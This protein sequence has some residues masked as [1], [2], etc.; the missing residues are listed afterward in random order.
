MRTLAELTAL[1]RRWLGRDPA[2]REIAIRSE[3]PAWLLEAERLQG[4]REIPG[5]ESSPDIMAWAARQ[6]PWIRAIYNADEVPWC[7]LFA[8]HCVSTAGLS[9][10][11]T[12]LSALAWADWGT[13]LRRPVLGAVAVFRRAGGGHVGFIVAESRAGDLHVLG[14]NQSDRVS[15]ARFSRER[16]VAVRWPEGIPMVRTALPVLERG[17]AL[18][19]KE[20]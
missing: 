14:G 13:P 8:A 20:A 3:R 12:P 5:S 6:A 17:I 1:I 11:E 2:A 18:S 4:I 10:P 9:V 7:G 19:T 16:L 15:T